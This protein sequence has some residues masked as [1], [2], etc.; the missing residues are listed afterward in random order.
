MGRKMELNLLK[1]T[2][3]RRIRKSTFILNIRMQPPERLSQVPCT[4]E[5]AARRDRP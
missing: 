4:G 1:D 5:G 2:W 3:E